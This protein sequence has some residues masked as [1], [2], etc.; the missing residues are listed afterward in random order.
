L[1]LF[2]F[3]QY[4]QLSPLT[5]LKQQQ[6]QQEEEDSPIHQKEKSPSDPNLPP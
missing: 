1:N 5:A 6:K 4:N 3:P 2:P